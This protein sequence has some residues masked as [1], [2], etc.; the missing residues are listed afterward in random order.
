MAELPETELASGV[1][2]FR[3]LGV[4]WF[5]SLGFRTVFSPEFQSKAHRCAALSL[6]DG[7]PN[8]G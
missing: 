6:S 1:L 7:D 4:W 3:G 5:R 2:E 8:A